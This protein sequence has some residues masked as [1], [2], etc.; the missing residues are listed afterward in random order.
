MAAAVSVRPVKLEWKCKLLDSQHNI[1]MSQPKDE[2]V[3]LTVYLI[4]S[5][6]Y[7]TVYSTPSDDKQIVVRFSTGAWLPWS[8]EIASEVRC[9]A[10]E[11]GK[12]GLLRAHYGTNPFIFIEHS[13]LYGR[14]IIMLV[15]GAQE[16][17]TVSAWLQWRATRSR[18][19]VKHLSWS[20]S[21]ESMHA[22]ATP[23]ICIANICRK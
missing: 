7:C 5:Q 15:P 1:E 17:R 18:D 22:L 8:E 23:T 16:L 13:S 19:L 12:G 3:L 20:C 14:Y 21:L 2:Q 9:E 11:G 10:V 4:P 6:L